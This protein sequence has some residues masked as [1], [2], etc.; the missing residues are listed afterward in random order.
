[1]QVGRVLIRIISFSILYMI[2]IGMSTVAGE[3]ATIGYKKSVKE[4]AKS[5]I[6]GYK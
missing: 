1:M 4:R 5:F 6:D 2:I 3:T